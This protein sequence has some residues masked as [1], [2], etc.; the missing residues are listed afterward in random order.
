MTQTHGCE[1]F[2][3]E[4]S[5]TQELLIQCQYILGTLSSGN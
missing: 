5:F 2:E 3:N 1:W 4:I